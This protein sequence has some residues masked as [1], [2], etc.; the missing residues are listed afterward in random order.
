MQK[1]SSWKLCPDLKNKFSCLEISCYSKITELVMT[2]NLWVV[3]IYEEKKYIFHLRG[4]RYLCIWYVGAPRPPL[5]MRGFSVPPP[6]LRS[7]HKCLA[8]Y[9]TAPQIP[10]AL[11]N[12]HPMT[13]VRRRSRSVEHLTHQR[14]SDTWAGLFDKWPLKSLLMPQYGLQDSRLR[15]Q[16]F[17]PFTQLSLCLAPCQYWM[18]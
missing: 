2:Q 15:V 8:S 1:K 6:R 16:H 13:N 4:E 14:E 18:K 17:W 3:H 7:S 5:P 10:L 9:C 11:P 12:R